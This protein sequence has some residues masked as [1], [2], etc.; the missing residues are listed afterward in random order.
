MGNISLLEQNRMIIVNVNDSAEHLSILE[1]I[2]GNTKARTKAKEA[3]RAAQVS[4]TKLLNELEN[5]SKNKS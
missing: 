3:L 2:P 5:L 4:I 1:N